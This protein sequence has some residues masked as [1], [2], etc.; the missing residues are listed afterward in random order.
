LGEFFLFMLIL[1]TFGWGSV[2]LAARLNRGPSRLE[3]TADSELLARLLEDMDRISTRLGQV[4]EELDFF[5]ELRAPDDP[6]RL[7]AAESSEATP[8]SVQ[9]GPESRS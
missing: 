2:F 6:R 3:S 8:I 4:E 9:D 5:K 1:F 7:G